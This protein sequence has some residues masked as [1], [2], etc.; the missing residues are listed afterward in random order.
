MAIANVAKE[1]KVEI[2]LLLIRVPGLSTGQLSAEQR[3]SAAELALQHRPQ[4][5]QQNNPS[6]K[7]QEPFPSSSYS[8]LE[9]S[10]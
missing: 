4:L 8:R 1:K 5:L 3:C 10:T 6:K 9:S 2:Y 7:K